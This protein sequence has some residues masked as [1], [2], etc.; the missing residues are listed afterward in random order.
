MVKADQHQI[1]RLMEEGGEDS[2]RWWRPSSPAGG[3]AGELK[4]KKRQLI[5]SW[6]PTCR[7]K[8]GGC[9]PCQAVHVAI[10]PGRSSPLEYYPEAW[11]CKCGKRLFMP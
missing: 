2:E 11:R 1:Q 9:T 5:G 3:S 7:A 8:C 10:Q 4:N 6:P